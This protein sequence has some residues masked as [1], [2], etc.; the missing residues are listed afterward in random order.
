MLDAMD[1]DSNLNGHVE[2]EQLSEVSCIAEL[3]ISYYSMYVF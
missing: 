1:R 3:F 2:Y